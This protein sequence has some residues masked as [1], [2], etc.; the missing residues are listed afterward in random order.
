MSVRSLVVDL[1]VA[2][3]DLLAGGVAHDH[4]RERRLELLVEAQRH[5]AWRIVQRAARRRNGLDQMGMGESW[6]ARE[7]QQRRYEKNDGRA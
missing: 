5:L 1:A 2:L 3:V 4:R 7:R 6:N